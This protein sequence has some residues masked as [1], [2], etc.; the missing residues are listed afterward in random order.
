MAFGNFFA[1]HSL[2]HASGEAEQ[3]QRVGD[4]GTVLSH[5]AGDFIMGQCEFIDQARIS[6]CPLNGVQVFA[7]NILNDCKFKLFLLSSTANDSRHGLKPGQFGGAQ[8]AF[9][10]NQR[11]LIR[12]FC[13]DDD[14]RLDDAMFPNGTSQIIQ[15]IAIEI[16]ARLMRVG[17]NLFNRNLQHLAGRCSRG[18]IFP[19]RDERIQA[20]A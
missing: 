10:G 2:L 5:F 20:F 15:S 1:F 4:G 9:P 7:L 17:Q 16:N 13:G 12:S 19:G 11:V 18:I 3:P 14:Q 6:L 8:A